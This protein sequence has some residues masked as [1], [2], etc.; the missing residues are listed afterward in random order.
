[1]TRERKTDRQIMDEDRNDV[2]AA[3]AGGVN[4]LME[5]DGGEGYTRR[6]AECPRYDVSGLMDEAKNA[7]VNC[8]ACTLARLGGRV[9]PLRGSKLPARRGRD[10]AGVA[11]GDPNRR[12]D[13]DMLLCFLLIEEDL[14][15]R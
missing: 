8:T 10:G 13:K 6:L 9:C 7:T 4:E 11:G 3:G 1:M 5:R 12:K 14:E 2:A 15:G